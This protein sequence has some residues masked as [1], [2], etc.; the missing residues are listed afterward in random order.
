MTVEDLIGE[1]QAM[2]PT[3]IVLTVQYEDIDLKVVGCTYAYGR[4][5]LE[6]ET[7][8]DTEPIS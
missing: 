1:L 3:A 5:V 4:V 2:P 8:E 6:T 7:L